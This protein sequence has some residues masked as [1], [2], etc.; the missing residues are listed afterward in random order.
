MVAFQLISRFFPHCTF[1][2]AKPYFTLGGRVVF[3]SLIYFRFGTADMRAPIL[4][5]SVIVLYVLLF[6]IRDGLNEQY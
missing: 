2:F 3:N 5:Q 6:F 1:R 4:Y